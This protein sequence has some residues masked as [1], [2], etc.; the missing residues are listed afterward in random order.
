MQLS[1]AVS[2]TVFGY[3]YC[4]AQRAVKNKCESSEK[5]E[6][7]L[8]YADDKYDVSKVKLVQCYQWLMSS[9]MICGLEISE[10]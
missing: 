2:N 1:V 7:W 4:A 8:Y 10:E 9:S 5:K 3:L 6:H